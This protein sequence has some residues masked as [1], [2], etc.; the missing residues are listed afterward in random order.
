LRSDW[1]ADSRQPITAQT[2][3]SIDRLGVLDSWCSRAFSGNIENSG[4]IENHV[5]LLDVL[6]KVQTCEGDIRLE[7]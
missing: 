5:L 7:I 1:L 6:E 3:P 4:I 2:R